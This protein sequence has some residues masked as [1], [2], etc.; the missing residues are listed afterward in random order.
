ME[1]SLP[2]LTTSSSKS[3]QRFVQWSTLKLRNPHEKTNPVYRGKEPCPRSCWRALPF[4]LPL[5]LYQRRGRGGLARQGGRWFLPFSAIFP[6][7]FFL[8]NLIWLFRGAVCP[9]LAG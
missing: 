1:A 9:S 5:L 6:C 8:G 3:I 7:G 2:Q 4:W